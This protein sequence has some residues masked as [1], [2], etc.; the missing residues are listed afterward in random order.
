MNTQGTTVAE[1][2]EAVIERILAS[3]CPSVVLHAG[4]FSLDASGGGNAGDHLS[5]D[6]SERPSLS[7][8]VSFARWTWDLGCRV[9]KRASTRG[10]HV[11]LTVLVND[12]QFLR[13]PDIPRRAGE[14]QAAA[15]RDAYYA[16]VPTLPTYYK[17]VME[18][19]QLTTSSVFRESDGRWLFS[20]S[21]LRRDFAATVRRLFVEGQA[22]DLGLEQTFTA[23]GEPIIRM[24]SEA[25]NQVCLLYCG[26]T[27]CAGEIVELL[28]Q[29]YARNVRHFLNLYPSPCQLPV[30]SGTS[31]ALELFQLQGL[32]VDNFAL[33]IEPAT[34]QDGATWTAAQQRAE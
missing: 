30:E 19:H 3:D 27:N 34:S 31:L 5:E 10:K 23:Q 32:T 9:A 13:S 28:R 7:G 2:E 21:A 20:E 6:V 11:A 15:L 8:I 22:T 26:S 17:T 14:R 12:W 29:L 1:L 16:E 24:G 33:S 25:S 4:H 18:R